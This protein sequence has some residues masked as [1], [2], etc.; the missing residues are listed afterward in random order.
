ERHRGLTVH[1]LLNL[2]S[3]LPVMFAVP[4]LVHC[5][6]VKRLRHPPGGWKNLTDDNFARTSESRARGESCGNS[7]PRREGMKPVTNRTPIKEMLWSA[8]SFRFRW[9]SVSFNTS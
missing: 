7:I 4:L 9:Q 2:T 6:G 1:F 5:I 8:C 3:R